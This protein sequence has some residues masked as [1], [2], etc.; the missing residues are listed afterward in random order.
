MRK[1]DIRRHFQYFWWC[2]ASILIVAVVFWT[3]VY[4]IIEKPDANEKLTISYFGN[5]Y[6]GAQL[7]LEIEKNITNITSQNIREFSVDHVN[8]TEDIV[9]G[10]MIQTRLY[11]SDIMIFEEGIITEEFASMN[12]RPFTSE[13]EACFSDMDLEYYVIDGIKYGIMVNPQGQN[14]NV[15][16]K[17]YSGNSTMIAFFAPYC[18][19]LGGIYGI[20]NNSD[21]AAIMLMRF[22]LEEIND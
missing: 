19:N 9:F 5:S 3:S 16:T 6:D 14:S 20:G 13:L 7:E 21:D 10:S 4:G 1:R 18:E 17:Y 11:S 22:L 2:Y 15:F 12:F 8:Q